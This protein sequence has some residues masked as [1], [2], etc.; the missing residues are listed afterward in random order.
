MRIP[1]EVIDRIVQ[2][3]DIVATISEFVT[4]KRRV[5]ITSAFVP[6]TRIR[7]PVWLSRQTKKI[8]KCFGCGEGGNVISFVQKSESISFPEAVDFV[9]SKYNITVPKKKT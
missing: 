1:N 4:L 5:L 6:F 9:A 8:W 2:S 3:A 7:M